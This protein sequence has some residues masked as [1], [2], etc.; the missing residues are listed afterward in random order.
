MVSERW[1]RVKRLV[2]QA[3]AREISERRRFLDE[4]CAGDDSLR[5]EV[6]SLLR[7]EQDALLDS[8]ATAEDDLAGRKLAHYRI[9][10]ELGRGGMGRVYRARDEK[11]DRSVALKVLPQ[12][13][14]AD[15]DRLR[16][17]EREARLIAAL[18]HPHVATIHGLDHVDGIHFLVLELVPGQTLRE[19]LGRGRLPLNE[20]LRVARQIAEALEAAHDKGVVHR[21]LKPSNVKVTEDGAVKVLD[22]GLAKAL[23]DRSSEGEAGADP[24]EVLETKEGIVMGTPAYMSPEQVAGIPVDHRTDVWSFGVVLWEMLTGERLFGGETTAEVL[25]AVLREDPVWARLPKDTPNAIRALLG[26]CLTR[27]RR[28]RLQAI[29]EARIAIERCLSGSRGSGTMTV[30]GLGGAWVPWRESSTLATPWRRWPGATLLLTLGAM[31]LLTV[32]LV[33]TSPTAT[34]V[35]LR[36]WSYTPEQK[37]VLSTHNTDVKLSPDGRHIAY[38]GDGDLW[39]QDLDAGRPRR[40]EGVGNA[41]DPF[42]SQDSAYVGYFH[43]GN[44]M[45]VPVQG[46]SPSVLCPIPSGE[47]WGGS[48]S[49]DGESVVVSSGFPGRLYEVPARGGEPK[50]VV[51]ASDTVSPGGPPLR[52]A[53]RPHFLPAE[54]G[55]RVVLFSFGPRTAL[56]LM[57]WDLETGRRK[58]LGAGALPSYSPGGYVVY[59]ENGLIYRLWALPFSLR[60]LDVT[61]R[62]F[63]IAS[64]GRDA[65][66]SADGTLVYVD[67][68]LPR[69]QLSWFD[70]RGNVVGH[71]GNPERIVTFP[72][73]SP[74]GRRL[75]AAAGDDRNFRDAWVYQLDHGT[76]T[77]LTAA[78]ENLWNVF[79]PV[80]SPPG[81][82]LAFTVSN[83]DLKVRAADGSGEAR[84]LLSTKSYQRVADWSPDGRLVYE[85]R[86]SRTG[87]D[88]SILERGAAGAWEQHVFLATPFEEEW[89]KVSRDGRYL[90]YCSNESGQW[91]VYVRPFPSGDRQWLV[92]KGGGAFPVWSRDGRELFYVDREDRLVSVAVSTQPGL[93]LG[94]TT[95]LFAYPAPS[96]ETFPFDVALDG[97]RFIIPATVGE[98]PPPVIH[99]VQNWAAEFQGE[100]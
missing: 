27:D 88:I 92:S 99:V 17:F 39:I 96:T 41:I 24:A 55:R 12:A 32:V 70:R 59:Q 100:R 15:P 79:A 93:S 87:T 20:A 62:P 5:A 78:P 29:A 49:P 4:S 56:N 81:D 85:V 90:A 26:R 34:K 72:A 94:G 10:G 1:E 30:P 74:D 71:V 13:F 35:P 38:H 69:V 64:S 86:T 3:L 61:G 91:E 76:R 48:W 47:P 40:I 42:W 2:D 95:P 57:V 23:R 25:G 66:V 65:A 43:G 6:E 83:R 68:D 51:D 28:Y 98:E 67:G 33:L 22:F 19:R 8:A 9:L 16:R 45:K 73:L 7:Y 77:R 89:A 14:A 18:S 44:V 52:S 54:A 46:G 60:T 75:A 97:S 53:Y 36:K 80:W 11:L 37:L 58:V 84:T 50:L 63:L 31:G 82:E 21:D